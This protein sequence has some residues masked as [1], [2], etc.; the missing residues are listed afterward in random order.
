M[1]ARTKELIRERRR[2][3][4]AYRRSQSDSDRQ[5]LKDID[6]ELARFNIDIPAILQLVAQR[7]AAEH[8]QGHHRQSG[9][10]SH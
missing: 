6:Q 10:P 1:D 5:R 8:H 4:L 7:G 9:H 2:V 3:A